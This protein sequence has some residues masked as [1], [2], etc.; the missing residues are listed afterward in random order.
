MRVRKPFREI[1]W[2]RRSVVHN[3]FRMFEYVFGR[4]RGIRIENRT[5]QAG[6]CIQREFYTLEALLAFWESEVY[7]LLLKPKGV[8]DKLSSV[9]IIELQP[10]TANGVKFNPVGYRF[11]IAEDGTTTEK[12]DDV[13]S[14]DTTTTHTTSGSDRGLLFS[15]N[16]GFSSDGGDATAIT[17]NSDS[18]TKEVSRADYNRRGAH[19]SLIAPDTGSNTAQVTWSGTAS[20]K[21]WVFVTMTGV[22][23]TDMVEATNSARATYPTTTPGISV[24]TLTDD[25][26]AIGQFICRENN[27]ITIDTGTELWYIAGGATGVGCA[28]G[29]STGS[30]G[31]ITVDWTTGGTEYGTMCISAV[32]PASGGGATFTPIISMI[33]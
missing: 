22:D 32:K 23:Q 1:E 9:E 27:T 31:S 2:S 7:S 10:I 33:T 13:S 18:L 12:A 24:T 6:E 21:V 15:T 8:W 4:K 28:G 16:W 20:D 26:W 11:A 29:Y 3:L 5:V 19:W 14:P 25:A 17:Y 30:A